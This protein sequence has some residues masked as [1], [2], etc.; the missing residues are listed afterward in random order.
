MRVVRQ[1]RFHCTVF[2]L[3]E[4]ETEMSVHKTRLKFPPLPSMYASVFLTAFRETRIRVSAVMKSKYFNWIN[5]YKQTHCVCCT[6]GSSSRTAAR[7]YSGSSEGP[8]QMHCPPLP[9]CLRRP[10]VSTVTV[11][12]LIHLFLCCLFNGSASSS[13]IV[14]W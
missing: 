9:T 11:M 4:H 7:L 5:L 2:Y 1:P 6:P 12:Q 14:G 13:Y 3:T 8:K 10:C